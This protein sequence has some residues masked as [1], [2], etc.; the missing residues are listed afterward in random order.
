MGNRLTS[1]LSLMQKLRQEGQEFCSVTIVR[2]ANA[3][4]AKAGAK[5]VVTRDG[6]LHGFLGGTCV[7]GAVRR[8]ALEALSAGAPR[9]IRVKP[10]E[11]VVT[12]VDADGVEL[13]KSSC[14]SGGTVDLFLEPMRQPV[15]LI[16]CG[17]SPVAAAVAP[18]ARA[19][20]YRV[21]LAAPADTHGEVPDASDY[22]D[23]FGLD[24]LG[25]TE[26]DMVLVATQGKRDR[27]ALRAALGSPAGYVGMVGSRRKIGKLR[28]ELA[29]DIPPRRLAEL[30]GPAGLAIG[31]IEPE[32]IAISILGEM[33]GHLR[34]GTRMS[35]EPAAKVADSGN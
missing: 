4:S 24:A 28:A 19:L 7:Q 11:E 14:P 13:Y 21:T 23:G 16:V 32:E 2:T 29:S 12:P 3:T 31:A 5:A 15:R 34:L 18:L 30:H 26:R 17:A 8:A 1:V 6:T 35:S 27:E 9:L 25:L 10:K 33:V 20:G 22:L